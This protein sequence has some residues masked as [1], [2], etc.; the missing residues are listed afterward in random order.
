[1]CYQV[2]WSEVSWILGIWGIA[3]IDTILSR[4]WIK[5]VLIRWDRW[6]AWSVSLFFTPDITRIYNVVRCGLKIPSKRYLFGIMRRLASWCW[7]V[8]P[9]DGIFNLLWT[10]IID[11]FSCILF[12][13]QL[14][15]SLHN[16]YAWFCQFDV[17][18]E[19]EHFVQEMFNS[20]PIHDVPTSCTRSSY[21]P[22]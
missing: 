4:Q 7:T 1:M 2:N 17:E 10:S 11:S 15:L 19:K 18:L 3:T 22:W 5:K 14:Y 6:T 21:T 16:G 9:S 12:L 8:V 20:A 13:W